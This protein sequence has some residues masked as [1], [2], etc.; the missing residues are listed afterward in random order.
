MEVLTEVMS[1]E[2]ETLKVETI[3]STVST[4]ETTDQNMPPFEAGVET[5]GVVKK[6]AFD[7]MPLLERQP[8]ETVRYTSPVHKPF[9]EKEHHAVTKDVKDP[10]VGPGKAGLFNLGNTCFMN[11]GLQCLFSNAHL[12]K[13]FLNQYH[14]SKANE[15]TLTGTFTKLL[16]KVW[17]SQYAVIHPLE[18]KQTLGMYHP[19]FQ[20]YRQHDCQEMLALLLD[21]LHEQLNAAVHALHPPYPSF[22]AA[23]CSSSY[24]HTMHSASCPSPSV[25]PDFVLEPCTANNKVSTASLAVGHIKRASGDISIRVNRE[26]EVESPSG[27]VDSIRNIENPMDSKSFPPYI[28][29]QSHHLNED[30][31]LSCQS[32]DSEQSVAI[33]RLKLKDQNKETQVSS[34]TDLPQEA[35]DMSDL[36]VTVS[37]SRYSLP[38]TMNNSIPEGMSQPESSSSFTALPPAISLSKPAEVSSS[39]EDSI[40]AMDDIFSGAVPGEA[41]SSTVESVDAAGCISVP[42]NVTPRARLPTLEDLYAKDTK[43]LNT[44][45]LATDYMDEEVQVD[46]EKFAKPENTTRPTEGLESIHV[47]ELA[48]TTEQKKD[49]PR[50]VKDTNIQ[51]ENLKKFRF[52]GKN[53]APSQSFEA[54]SD[55]SLSINNVKRMKFE[56]T[57]KNIKRQALH[58]V[59]REK[60]LFHKSDILTTHS[61]ADSSSEDDGNND[62]LVE[63]GEEGQSSTSRNSPVEVSHHA[64]VESATPENIEAANQAWNEYL[65]K[66]R[67]IVVDTFQGQFRSTVICSECQHVSVTHEPF[68]YLSVPLPHAM[69]RQIS[70]IFITC[71]MPPTRYLFTMHKNDN[72]QKLKKE[73]RTLL[74]LENCDIIMAEVLDSHISRI[75]DDSVMLGYVNDSTR[76]IYAFNML[77]AP[78]PLISEGEITEIES[79][80]QSPTDKSC[81]LNTC[82]GQEYEM[83]CSSSTATCTSAESTEQ[84]IFSNVGLFSTHKLEEDKEGLDMPD[85]TRDISPAVLEQR[86]PLELD[87]PMLPAGV[88]GSGFSAGFDGETPRMNSPDLDITGVQAWSSTSGSRSEVTSSDYVVGTWTMDIVVDPPSQQVDVPSTQQWRSCAICLEEM[89]DSDL[90]VHPSCEGTLCQSCLEMSFKHYGDVAFTCP[91]C[92]IPVNPVEGFLPLGG[93]S[94][95]NSKTRLLAVHVAYRLDSD[96]DGEGL[97]L[98][99]HPNVVYLYSRMRGQDLYDLIDTIIPFPTTFNISLTDGQ[100]LHCSRCGFTAHCTGCLVLR[101][102][103]VNLQPGDHLTITVS[104]LSGVQAPPTQD[105]KSMEKLRP[106]DPITIYDCFRAFTESEILDEHNPWYCPQCTQN[107]R[108]R[109]TMTVWRYPDTLII[110]LKRFVFHEL[111]STKI[112]NKVVFPLDN[113]DLSEFLSGPRT[114]QLLYDLHG[115]VCHFGGANAGHYTAYTKHPLLKQWFYYN[116]ETVTARE[117]REDD[118]SSA[119]VLFYQRQGTD[120]RFDPLTELR[121][122]ADGPDPC[123]STCE[124]FSVTSLSDIRPS[125]SVENKNPVNAENLALILQNLKERKESTVQTCEPDT[126]FDF[127]L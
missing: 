116:D 47:N 126:T 19:Q 25:Q 26:A 87:E 104:D 30:S 42:N 100:G 53:N 62:N 90:M 46:S 122:S 52:G 27:S 10:S 113:L 61:D 3:S 36:G 79:M 24:D 65:E 21:T 117:P 39:Q 28:L 32:S 35:A 94:N 33:S 112:D 2:N 124:G 77:P 75:L 34:S 111:S 20:D 69:E 74:G 54:D 114:K 68:M 101:D 82:T 93:Q 97:H 49:K 95:R 63:M 31:N 99:S 48:L 89:V 7:D 44:N 110:H 23:S 38:N 84:D 91:V 64:E 105:H 13:F 123:S 66:N 85:T 98:F 14:L 12:V 1:S 120:T 80:D 18:F 108:A 118:H 11:S 81:L 58:K 78:P 29:S 70:V 8:N 115:I 51:A 15:D 106:R 67:S 71:D 4:E 76:L 103:E 17:S 9:L 45:V 55:D 5:S 57:E 40:I 60:F 50:L 56:G 73:L 72:I 22:A 107:Q 102:S 119:Y 59:N 6:V 83:R 121:K 37:N 96:Q 86:L 127:Y 88:A 41:E 125:S 92:S 109:K 16:Y 43:T